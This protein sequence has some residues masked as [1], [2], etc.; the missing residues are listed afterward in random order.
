MRRS[1]LMFSPIS[2]ELS[3]KTIRAITFLFMALFSAL[4]NAG[5]ASGIWTSSTAV[6]TVL[7]EQFSTGRVVA[8]VSPT[9]QTGAVLL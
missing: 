2:F 4:A 5:P 7:M 1:Q 3:M 6:L 8:S 9:L